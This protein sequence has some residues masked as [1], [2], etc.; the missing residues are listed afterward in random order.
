LE[1]NL[2]FLSEYGGSSGVPIEVSRKGKAPPQESG[3]GQGIPFPIEPDR[4]LSEG[5]LSEEMIGS[6]SQN[7][8][9][10]EKSMG[11]RKT[12]NIFEE[13]PGSLGLRAPGQGD[14][15]F[16]LCPKKQSAS[17]GRFKM[18]Q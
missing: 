7:S 17:L 5:I 9:L 1:R 10:E 15:F 18:V 11:S 14:F 2:L 13:T 12:I 4:Q 16:C 3:K 8:S 6:D